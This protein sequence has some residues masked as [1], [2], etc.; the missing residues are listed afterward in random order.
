MKIIILNLQ[1]GS[2]KG[3]RKLRNKEPYDLF[4]STD[5]IRVTKEES[6]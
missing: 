4:P 3:L 6:T 1:G 2:N 5:M